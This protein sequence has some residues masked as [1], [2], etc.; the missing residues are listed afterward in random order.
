MWQLRGV[1][2]I[3]AMV[4]I[5]ATMVMLGWAMRWQRVVTVT[6]D[7]PAMQFCT[8]LSLWLLG[9]SL[10]AFTLTPGSTRG[11]RLA[12][13][14]TRLT[15]TLSA[16]IAGLYLLELATGRTL[17]VSD[18]FSIGQV[19]S[20]EIHP[21]PMAPATALSI[22]LLSAA[23][24]LSTVTRKHAAPG[25][26]AIVSALGA[27]AIG[28]HAGVTF[29][30]ARADNSAI[31]FFATMG[32][33]TAWIVVALGA[34]ALMA[35]RACGVLA[36]SAAKSE[37]PRHGILLTTLVRVA[38]G[39]GIGVT[40]V[41][42]GR[43]A[44]RETE[45]ARARFE[46]IAERVVSEAQRRVYLPVYGLRGAK[47]MYVGSEQVTRSEFRDYVTS[48]DLPVE[49]PGTIGMGF[50]ER[51]T[52]AE[53]D[54]FT[55]RERAD[56]E[57]EFSVSTDGVHDILYP[58]SRVE[59]IASNR[60]ALGYDIGSEPHR[61]D[62]VEHAM[63]TGEPRLTRR[64][65][66]VQDERERPGF[67]FMVPIYENGKP[68]RTQSEREVWGVGVVYA[69]M[70]IDEIFV[71]FRNV[72][73]GVL[74]YRVYEGDAPSDDALLFEEG[75]PALAGTPSR[76][77]SLHNIQTGGQ[78]WTI[79]MEST[80][81]FDATVISPQ[82]TLTGLYGIGLS[83]VVSCLIWAIGGSRAQAIQ[84]AAQMTSDLNRSADELRL[85]SEEIEKKNAELRAMAER[86]HH[87]VDD[88]SHEFR[89]PLSVIKEFCA[90]M[91]EGLAGPVTEDQVKYLKI[92]DVSVL[93]LNQMVEDFLDSS[94]LRAGRL[95]V[96]RREHD[97]DSIFT[98]GRELLARRASARSIVIEESIAPGLPPVFADEEKVRRVIS[99][100]MTNAIKF[101][102]E[103]GV[104]RLSA[105]RSET[106]GMITISVT[107]Q[108]A[109]L[110][111]ADIDH[112]FGRFQQVSTS[113]NVAAKG[114]GLG[115]SIAQE[116]TWLNLG[117]LT[118]ESVKG[119]GA[120]FSF[121][122]PEWDRAVVLRNYARALGALQRPADR[123]ALLRV[124]ISEHE[125]TESDDDGM[126]TL[127]FLGSTTMPTDLVL[128]ADPARPFAE[129]REWWIIGQTSDPRVWAERI[130]AA[131][132]ELVAESPRHLAA[133]SIDLF[134][135]WNYP[136]EVEAA[137]R[138]LE[139]MMEK[140]SRHAA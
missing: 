14:I 89:T 4:L 124:S 67:L 138:E 62:A 127:S 101:S 111:K 118:V 22:L 113:R 3:G 114:F 49:F 72:S 58:I 136:D 65:T 40:V 42:T 81:S 66:L 129:Q 82:V 109:G 53:L 50:V 117:S 20:P 139:L 110:S 64:I 48:R 68:I 120:T 46:R 70:V 15:S 47:G 95:R 74:S 16:S 96:L 13:A 131:R 63:R 83:T 31:P 84:L 45:A 30:T 37:S 24:P 52:R 88:V 122:L 54:A 34:G 27:A 112:L 2:V 128:P 51:I 137:V 5:V 11:A 116:L 107:D 8:A 61:R 140:E 77:R 125:A 102:P 108:G 121:T 36:S 56:G 130:R 78:S 119:E 103:G 99:N 29:L 75:A 35:Y 57:P 133:M 98:G 18:W 71:G 134:K 26:L 9:V 132:R 106:P 91:S 17:G 123:L 115:L 100:L 44:Q 19:I 43:A 28:A 38:F 69:A 94:K 60:P 73:E 80:P 85:S 41:E 135:V 93:G 6:P 39:V 21:A 25:W 76:F 12:I 33:H 10:V 87:V 105:D 126:E 59:P 90:I 92:V 7:L 79:A 1:R 97:V 23:I 32:V 55:E 86:A 104:I